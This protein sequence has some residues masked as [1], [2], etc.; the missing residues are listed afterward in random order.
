M[1]KLTLDKLT[2]R[3]LLLPAGGGGGPMEPLTIRIDGLDHPY[4]GEA[5]VR[6]DIPLRQRHLPLGSPDSWQDVSYLADSQDEAGE[7]TI[8]ALYGVLGGMG[9]V[10]AAVMEVGGT[11]CSFML[12]DTTAGL[13]L[14]YLRGSAAEG[15][16]W[17]IVPFDL[18]AA[19]FNAAFGLFERMGKLCMGYTTTTD[20][21]YLAQ[22]TFGEHPTE[23]L[24]AEVVE[25]LQPVYGCVGESYF[26]YLYDL[27]AFYY[28]PDFTSESGIFSCPFGLP[29]SY[30][31]FAAQLEY[32][33]DRS[34]V[35]LVFYVKTGTYGQGTYS[36]YT[37]TFDGEQVALL[38][39][40]NL[41][42]QTPGGE[43]I[44]LYDYLSACGS[45][46]TCCTYH[47]LRD[48]FML[49]ACGSSGAWYAVFT[50]D[51]E[52]F[53]FERVKSTP[54]S[55]TLEFN[56]GLTC[57]CGLFY[58]YAGEGGC[59]LSGPD[60]HF[61]QLYENQWDNVELYDAYPLPDAV[62]A[63]FSYSAGYL[64]ATRDRNRW[65]L[66]EVGSSG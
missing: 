53:D 41:P 4:T 45:N 49:M 62:L 10:P 43:D 52:S 65:E 15:Y 51:F 12:A 35:A 21:C 3:P 54:G 38:Q 58:A 28:G 25:T 42:A 22:L 47:P 8:Y 23:V 24:E 17:G 5:P 32:S 14:V 2:G 19:E 1:D 34:R 26:G 18:A 55:R 7:H 20:A 36:T 46:S 64:Q 16:A 59:W 40:D 13:C 60:L 61:Y 56:G 66:E 31:T 44:Y 63:Y 27:Q 30:N 57:A 48:A 50:T 29:Y 39:V 9:T 11:R 33:L 37:A 6:L